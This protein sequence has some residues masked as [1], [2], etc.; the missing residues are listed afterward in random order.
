MNEKIVARR[1]AAH[2]VVVGAELV[3]GIL[4]WNFKGAVYPAR[5]KLCQETGR[6]TLLSGPQSDWLD[7]DGYS[8]CLDAFSYL[9]ANGFLVEGRFSGLAEICYEQ[10]LTLTGNV[11]AD[12]ERI[13][14]LLRI[15][16][17]SVCTSAFD[18]EVE[19]L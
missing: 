1:L 19:A 10:T 14:S 7:S 17:L 6:L 5:L 3:D 12:E 11:E 16:D 15:A 9:N 18:L 4:T 13:D 2:G 8:A